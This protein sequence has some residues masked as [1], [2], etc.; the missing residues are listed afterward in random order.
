M[1]TTPRHVRRKAPLEGALVCTR[2]GSR[3]AL[4]A[5]ALD[6]AR[7]ELVLATGFEP[8]GGSVELSGCCA[9]C[10]GERRPAAWGVA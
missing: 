1:L 10:R 3:L 9:R 8:E 7:D 4:D 2:C 6:L 5:V